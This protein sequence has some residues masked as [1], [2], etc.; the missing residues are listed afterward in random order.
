MVGHV[1][2]LQQQQQGFQA[3]VEGRHENISAIKKLL[4]FFCFLS[5]LASFNLLILVSHYYN[6]HKN[7]VTSTAFEI[8]YPK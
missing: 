7:M 8:S 3:A 2:V 1:H 4:D 5:D 6:L